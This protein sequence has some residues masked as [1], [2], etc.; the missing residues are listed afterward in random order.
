M[1]ICFATYEGVPLA[2]GGPYIK[3]IECK[4]ELEKLGHEVELF[5]MWTSIDKIKKFDIIHL[6]GSNLAIYGFARNLFFNKINFL[7]EPVFF[8]SH[9]P[10]FLRRANSIDKLSRKFLPG[11]WFDY[12]FIRDICNWSDL[13]LPN[14]IEEKNLISNG[15]SISPNKF[16][17]I[18]NGVSERFLSADPDLFY[19]KY[20]LK[21]FILNVGHIGP[22]RKNVL[23]LVKALE[24]INHQAVIIGKILN[25]GET[26]EVKQIIQKNKN[27]LFIEELGNNSPLLASAY[28]A[29]NTF[30]LP[31]LFETPGIAALEAALCGAKIANY[32][33]WRDKGLFQRYG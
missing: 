26:E 21:D 13:V 22:K 2:K 16:S 4:E 29:C 5:N 9:S 30:V 24:K 27:I 3:I 8:S 12:G 28:A 20:G 6:V 1:K 10:N 31:S 23:A 32:S 7:A 15:F 25:T 33:V 18:P 17:I 19:K 11:V 14:T